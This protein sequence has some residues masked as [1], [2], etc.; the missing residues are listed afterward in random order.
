MNKKLLLKFVF[1]GSLL[2]WIIYVKLDWEALRNIVGNLKIHWLI[3]AFLMHFTGLFFSAWRWKCLLKGQQIDAEL[4]LLYESYLISSFFNLF[5]PTRIGG[6]TVRIL[7]LNQAIKSIPQSASSVVLERLIGISVLCIFAMIS[8]S[9]GLI[10]GNSVKVIWIGLFSGF[11]G[12]CVCFLLVYTDI[13]NGIISFFPFKK[14]M[15]KVRNNWKDFS[16]SIKRI[17]SD[18]SSVFMGVII[19]VFLQ[20]N[21]IIH[22]WLI[23]MALELNI[24]FLDY[25]FLIPIQLFILMLPSINGIGL[26]EASCIALFDFYA[27]DPTTAA[28]FGFIDLFMMIIIGVLG[29]VCFMRKRKLIASFYD[30]SLKR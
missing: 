19:S 4:P 25:F 23:G 16:Q 8:S 17:S 3:I 27:I 14:T 1:S 20:L 24:K 2:I 9:I 26:R 28:M 6:D 10:M 15:V 29:W 11:L 22:F 7:H 13:V 12:V 18:Y 5:M 30:Q 21:V